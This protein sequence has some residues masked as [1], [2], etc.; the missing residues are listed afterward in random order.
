MSSAAEIQSSF[1][2]VQEFLTPTFPLVVADEF[3]RKSFARAV[4][5]DGGGNVVIKTA[6]GFSRTLTAIEDPYFVELKITEITS[7]TAATKVRLF[8]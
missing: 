4:R 5:I 7:A 3:P 8:V 2:D 6:A 1:D